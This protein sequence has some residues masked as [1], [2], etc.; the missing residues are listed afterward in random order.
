MQKSKVAVAIGNKLNVVPAGQTT[1]PRV[2]RTGDGMEVCIAA[3][4]RNDIRRYMAVLLF[5]FKTL[6]VVYVTA[7]HGIRPYP[8]GLKGAFQKADHRSE[9]RRVGNEVRH[10]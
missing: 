5:L 10:T 2:V 8:G 6:I 3:G 7:E 9:E 4:S 1:Y